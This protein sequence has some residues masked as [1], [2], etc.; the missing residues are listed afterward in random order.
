MFD[1]VLIV[2]GNHL[3][4]R[5]YFKFN[6][7]KTL[8][9]KSTSILY[10]SPYILESII[11]KLAP[12]KVI[13]VF[14]HSR[15][16]FRMGLLKNYKQRESKLG[17]NK[18]AF[19]A[20]KDE[21]MY[22][23]QA[24]GLEVY[25]VKGYEADDIIAHLAKVYYRKKHEVIILSADKDFVQLINKGISM[26]HVSKGIL[27]EQDNCKDAYDYLPNQCV[28]FLC[29]CGDSSDK[30]DGYP[31]IGP[32]RA[33]KLLTEHGSVRKFI[34]SDAAFG[35]VDKERLGIIYERN[36]KLIDLMYFLRKQLNPKDIESLNPNA[37]LNMDD[38]REICA[39]NEINSFTRI[40]FLKTFKN[41]SDGK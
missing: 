3:I 40:Q 5:A 12:D 26:Y 21:L 29:L 1:R 27:V 35:K 25:H 32:K 4:Y 17:D 33:M 18:E 39:V 6:N 37:K 19:H 24:F 34:K 13:V 11:R 2:D 8:D 31:G 10:G 7:L 41:L 20:Q 36:R 15:S 28:D 14:D 9:G 30:I 38:L 22:L 23:F 16:K